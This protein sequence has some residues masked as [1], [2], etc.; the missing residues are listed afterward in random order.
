MAALPLRR[1]IDA[2]VLPASE[3]AAMLF[4]QGQSEAAQVLLEDE[5]ARRKALDARLWDLLFALLRVQGDW[6]RFDAL[7]GQYASLTRLPMP[8]WLDHPLLARLPEPMQV[9]GPAYVELYEVAPALAERVARIAGQHNGLHLDLSRLE[10]LDAADV[11]RLTDVLERLAQGVAAVIVSGTDP[12]AMRIRSLLES[13]PANLLLWRLLLA[14]YRLQDLDDDFDQAC[15]EYS[16]ATGFA[17]PAWE[18][19]LSPVLPTLGVEEKRRAPRYQAAESIRL[20]GR[21]DES[22]DLQLELLR[23]GAQDRQYVNV[24]LSRLG[25]I[26]PS[27]AATLVGVANELAG[28]GRVV[29]LLRPHALIET[30]LQALSLDPRV[31]LVRAQS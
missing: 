10:R 7:A 15:L 2:Q 6:R 19:P 30:L 14:L 13:R 29:R 11:I 12:F 3:Q 5:L 17:A 1:L 28:W 9:G 21:I 26:A 22:T 20:R 23:E 31:Q 18:R 16:L 25:R 24:D 8:V 27:P 4:A